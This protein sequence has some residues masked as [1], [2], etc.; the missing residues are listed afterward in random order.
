[1]IATGAEIGAGITPMGGTIAAAFGPEAGGTALGQQM[2]ASAAP[3]QVLGGATGM[4]GMTAPQAIPV[5]AWDAAMGQLGALPETISNGYNNLP[6][7]GQKMVDSTVMS[8][9]MPQQQAQRGS[10]SVRMPGSG[11]GQ[12][13]A[14]NPPFDYGAPNQQLQ[15][16]AGKLNI[17]EEDLKRILMSLRGF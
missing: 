2:L 14:A 4:A 15:G 9:L 7:V 1:M 3:T 12:A 8:T 17:S 16:A 5:T 10:S 13:A 6:T 11:G